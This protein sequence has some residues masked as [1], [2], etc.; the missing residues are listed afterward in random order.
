MDMAG[1]ELIGHLR[2]CA[3][4]LIVDSVRPPARVLAPDLER[5]VQAQRLLRRPY[6][7]HTARAMSRLDCFGGEQAGLAAFAL[8]P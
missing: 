2:A 6:C 7:R 1:D 3:A 5:S 8:M 4:R